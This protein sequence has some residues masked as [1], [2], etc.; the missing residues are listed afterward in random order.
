MP[1]FNGLRVLSLES[2]RADEMARHIEANGGVATVAPSMREVPLESNAEAIAFAHTLAAA[3][4]DVVILLTGVGTRALTRVVETVYPRERFVELLKQVAVVPRGPKP[5]AALRE[6]GVPFALAVPEPN[7]WREILQALDDNAEKV[8]IRGR[9]VAVQEYG[10]TNPDLLDGLAARGAEVTRVPVYAWALPL[11]T[12]PLRDAV[13]G[14]ARGEFDVL[15][16][17]TSVQV[18]HMLQVAAEMNL[19]EPLRDALRRTLVAWIGP[20]TTETLREHG[21]DADLEPSHPKMGYLVR[22]TAER[23]AELLRQKRARGVD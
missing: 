12:A 22:E 16:L 15:L 3:G 13:A 2:R 10:V 4:F 7:T 5:I 20:T 1:G 6:L 19:E 23:S 11:N 18:P 8:P 21:L 17:T 9:R 14:L